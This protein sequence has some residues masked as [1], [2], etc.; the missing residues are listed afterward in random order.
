MLKK[1]KTEAAIMVQKYCKGWMVRANYSA[2]IKKRQMN[3]FLDYF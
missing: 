1:K 2:E 3:E